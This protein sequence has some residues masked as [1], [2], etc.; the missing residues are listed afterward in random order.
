MYT[1]LSPKNLARQELIATNYLF[2]YLREV[3]VGFSISS[4]AKSCNV[5]DY[6][7]L[8]LKTVNNTTIRVIK[9]LND[10]YY[11]LIT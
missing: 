5:H 1:H 3:E 11:Y 9:T 7:I 4:F 8:Y 6:F 10:R 2:S